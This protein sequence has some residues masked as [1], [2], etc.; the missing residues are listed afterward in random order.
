VCRGAACQYSCLIPGMSSWLWLQDSFCIL[1]QTVLM[2]AL[3]F[4]NEQACLQQPTLLHRHVKLAHCV[5]LQALKSST[6]GSLRAQGGCH[7]LAA[8]LLVMMLA[9]QAPSMTE[10]MQHPVAGQ[11]ALRRL[12]GAAAVMHRQC[13]TQCYQRCSDCQRDAYVDTY[14]AT[15][16]PPCEIRGCDCFSC[17]R[18]L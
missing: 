18:G 17:A 4:A 7:V 12:K 1:E 6:N 5:A 13:S 16:T 14:G 15:N 2:P 8:V 3:M 9:A 10:A 11:P